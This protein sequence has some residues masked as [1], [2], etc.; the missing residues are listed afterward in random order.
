MNNRSVVIV[1]LLVSLVSVLAPACGDKKNPTAP[2]PTPTGVTVTSPNSTIL[3]GQTEQMT[4]TVTLSTG[5][6]QVGTGTWGSDTPT[7]ATVSQTG[8]V[9]AVSPGEV[10]IYFDATGDGRGTKRLRVNPKVV[11]LTGTVLA[12]GGARLAG[13]TVRIL[14]GVNAGRS[15][16]TTGTG[17]YVIEGL[18]ID[19]AN[20]S[21]RANGYEQAAKGVHI[22]G[23]NRLDF[24]LRTLVPWTR[25][26]VG[27]TVF[28][29]PS[30]FSRVRII[31][32][33]TG[34]SS[35]FIVRIGGRLTVN[36]LV[37]IGWGQTRYDGVHNNSGGVVE[38]T[39]SSG[40]SWSITEER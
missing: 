5:T 10:T 27:N 36:E 1:A 34:Y 16:T 8:L 2:T 11:S 37:G 14:D 40:V 12:V 13:A 18:S 19:D 33:Y 28:D 29:M 15:A 35:N 39:N 38:I 20:V 26:G 23:T 21:A 9:T 22:N 3:V 17:D 31:G 30:Y 24:T 4:A 25:S 32:I 6:T 7:V